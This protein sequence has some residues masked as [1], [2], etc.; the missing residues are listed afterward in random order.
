MIVIAP[1][2]PGSTSGDSSPAKTLRVWERPADLSAIADQL[3]T[4]LPEGLSADTWNIGA[5]GFSLGGYVSWLLPAQVSAYSNIS[6]IA[7]VMP[8]SPN[9]AVSRGG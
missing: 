3:D 4:L 7:T 1:N 6:I 9:A 2:H 5:V 8:T